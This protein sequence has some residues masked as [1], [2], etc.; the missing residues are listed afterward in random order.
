MKVEKQYIKLRLGALKKLSRN[1]DSEKKKRHK[2]E[3]EIVVKMPLLQG[4]H[5]CDEWAM[6]LKEKLEFNQI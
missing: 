2:Y 4:C 5:P 1:Y 6:R 3:A